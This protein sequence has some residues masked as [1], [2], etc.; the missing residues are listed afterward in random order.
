M[1]MTAY[2]NAATAGFRGR[3]ASS[4]IIESAVMLRSTAQVLIVVMLF[5]SGRLLACGVECL[6]ELAAPAQASCHQESARDRGGLPTV[7][8]A[9]VGEVHACLPEIV[10]P[11]VTVAKL[12]TDHL[13][14]APPLV[15]RLVAETPVAG[16]VSDRLALRPPFESP[17]L[18]SFSI[19]R[20]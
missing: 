5:A 7:A 3:P 13:L 19:L 8:S 6:D 12:A 20:I 16:S 1:V 4:G 11:R 14:V 15:A 10:E 17:H 18:P 9:K 2:N